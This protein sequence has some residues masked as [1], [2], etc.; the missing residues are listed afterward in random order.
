MAP[1][2][3]AFQIPRFELLVARGQYTA[4]W[5]PGGFEL[6]S[7]DPQSPRYVVRVDVLDPE[8]APASQAMA[9]P[10]PTLQPRQRRASRR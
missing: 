7:T 2:L 5:V 8:P 10:L 9:A 3:T 4:H 1:K 6:R